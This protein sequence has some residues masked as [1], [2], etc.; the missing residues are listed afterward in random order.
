MGMETE[1]IQFF[2]TSRPGSQ[3]DGHDQSRNSGSEI[4]EESRRLQQALTRN[5]ASIERQVNSVPQSEWSL[6][7]YLERL[8][9]RLSSRLPSIDDLDQAIRSGMRSLLH[10][11]ARNRDRRRIRL[12]PLDS[13][14]NETLADPCALQ[15]VTALVSQD[16]LRKFIELL[17]PWTKAALYAIHIDG[18][19]TPR[20]I[21]A[22]RM[23][24]KENSFNKRFQRK[25]EKAKEEYIKVYG[26]Y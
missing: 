13:Q 5:L 23:G 6:H 17:D 15:F 2:E 8:Y 12:R 18:E 19:D 25:M 14:P 20:A 7:E 26:R 16:K 1:V 10:E 9:K 11:D 24:M 3:P 4:S 21:I 22:Q